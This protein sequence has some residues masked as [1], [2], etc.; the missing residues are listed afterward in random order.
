MGKFDGFLLCT[1]MDGTLLTT[2]KRISEENKQAI[3]YFKSEGGLFT[4]ATGRTFEGANPI[5]EQYTP[6]IP[7]IAFNGAA[8]YDINKKEVLFSQAIDSN[9]TKIVD[10]V[11]E[12][13]PTAGIDICT[14][15][16]SYFYRTN[17]V[18]EEHKHIERLPDSYIDDYSQ[19]QE[20]WLKIIFMVEP[21][22]MSAL[23]SLIENSE[24]AD[25]FEFVQSEMWYYEALPKNTN[26]GTA[27]V[28]LT[29]MLNIPLEKTIAIGD[30]GNDVEFVKKAGIGV[31]VANA[32]PELLDCADCITVDN[33]S[34]AIK[35]LVEALDRSILKF[36]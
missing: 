31:A 1:D 4:F 5:I 29:K 26:K 6:D 32:V 24:Y 33:N 22:E 8:I 30:N 15:K 36:K 13:H 19:I 35:A 28:E 2:D 17:R 10:L 34:H 11:A 16:Q 27:L 7:M 25:M 9:I 20:K 21:E 12:K 3:E 14:I 23:R 18:L